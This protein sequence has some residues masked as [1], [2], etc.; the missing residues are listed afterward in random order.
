MI[1]TFGDLP[2]EVHNLF[3]ITELRTLCKTANIEK[4]DLGQKGGSI[5]FKANKFHNPDGL[6]GL[7]QINNKNVK[8]RPDQSLIYMFDNSNREHNIKKLI[9]LINQIAKL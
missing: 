3:M 4:I 7:I 8:L 5:K 9:N 1:D 6:V 2:N